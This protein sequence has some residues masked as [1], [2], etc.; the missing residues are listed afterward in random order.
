MGPLSPHI[1]EHIPPHGSS[2]LHGQENLWKTTWRS[3]GRVECDF[4][5]GESS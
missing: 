5:C 2:I 1:A 4:G 3:Y